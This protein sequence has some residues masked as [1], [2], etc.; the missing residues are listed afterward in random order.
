VD[1][2]TLLN[3]LVGRTGPA[4]RWGTVLTS[5]LEASQQLNIEAPRQRASVKL[6]TSSIAQHTP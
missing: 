2:V 6:A 3:E 1:H 5:N 4:R